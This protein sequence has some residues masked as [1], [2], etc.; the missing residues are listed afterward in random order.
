MREKIGGGSER[1]GFPQIGYASCQ[2]ADKARIFAAMPGT[3]CHKPQSQKRGNRN[4]QEDPSRSRTAGYQRHAGRR[5]RGPGSDAKTPLGGGKG[6]EWAGGRR[7]SQP[8]RG[9]PLR[10]LPLRCLPLRCQPLPV[11]TSPCQPLRC[12]PLRCQPLRGQPLQADLSGPTS[13]GP[14]SPVPTS[15]ANLSG[16]TSPG[17]PTGPT[18]PVPTSPGPTSPKADLSGPTSQGLPPGPTSPC[19]PLRANL[20]RPTS[21]GLPGRGPTSPVPTSPGQPLR[22][23]LSGPTSEGQPPGPTPSRAYLSRANLSGANLSGAYP[24]G[25][26]IT[27]ERNWMIGPIGSRASYCTAYATD[28]G[29]RFRAGCFLVPKRNFSRRSKRATAATNMRRTRAWIRMCRSG[30]SGLLANRQEACAR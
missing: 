4:D 17:L 10:C 30:T 27:A 5:D 19:Q 22:A 11:P 8:L 20:S 24:T 2:E 29:L 13:P 7:G 28:K 25:R 9:Q 21:R 23:D 12:Q 15:R 1:N 16:P 26:K 6:R 3:T 18:S 14:T